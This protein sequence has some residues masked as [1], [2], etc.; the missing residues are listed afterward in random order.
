MGRNDVARAGGK[1]ANLGELLHAGIPVPPGFIVLSE[2][3]LQVLKSADVREGIQ[4]ALS[5]LDVNDSDSLN[6]ASDR[7]KGL[8]RSAPVPASLEAAITAAYADL[9]RGLVAVR[10]SATAED[11]AE[12]SFAGQQETFLNVQGDAHVLASVRDCWASLFEPRAIFYRAGAGFDHLDVGIA[13]VVQKMVQSE[14]SGVMFTIH[15]VTNDSSQIVIEAVYGLGEAIVSGMVTPD[16]YV[17]DKASGAVLDVQVVP[18]ESELVRATH[19]H[20]TE[21]GAEEWQAIAWDRRAKQK[22]SEEQLRDLTVLGRR[23]EDYFGGPQDIEWAYADGA[24]YIVQAR[25]VTT[26]G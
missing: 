14:V 23:I 7:V 11:L 16:S 22:L 9:G 2:A 18:Q 13:V 1:G 24:F 10:S 6:L 4:G 25:P 3:Y 21:H 20:T 8:I 15:P 17:V 19:A 5:G 12:A 26:A